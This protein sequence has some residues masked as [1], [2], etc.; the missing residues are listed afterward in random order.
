MKTEFLMGC[1]I[2]ARAVVFAALLVITIPGCGGGG[3]SQRASSSAS[4]KIQEM[5]THY[6]RYLGAHNGRPPA[7]EQAFRDFLAENP[8]RYQERGMSVDDFFVAPE[9]GAPFQWAYGKQLILDIYGGKN[10]GYENS[11]SGGRRLVI[12][13]RGFRYIEDA[14]FREL[15]PN[16]P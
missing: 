1:R 2:A 8:E 6:A 3:A 10:Y 11:S 7:D 16:L 12:A 9:S 15:F 13:D 5:K 4:A 14:E